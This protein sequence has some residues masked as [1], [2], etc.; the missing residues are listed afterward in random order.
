M[1]VLILVAALTACSAQPPQ[2]AE[3]PAIA[4]T[5]S[6]TRAAL[7]QMPSWENARAAGVDF[8]AIGQEPGWLVDV[9]TENRIVA[10]LDYGETLLDFPRTEPTYPVEGSTRYETEADGHTLVITIRRFPC[11]DVMSGEDY[12]ATVEVVIDERT[13]NGCGRSV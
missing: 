13:L 12:P 7:S 10:L 3:P 1:R 5:A 2:Q 11:Q 6:E 8:R 9:Y 4:E